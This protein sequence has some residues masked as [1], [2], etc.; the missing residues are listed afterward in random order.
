MH[1]ERA[2]NFINYYSEEKILV[3]TLVLEILP[4][5]HLKTVILAHAYVML[6]FFPS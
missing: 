1:Y 2:A 5:S 3:L 6:N 4:Y